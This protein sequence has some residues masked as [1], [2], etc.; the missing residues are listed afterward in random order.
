[1][2]LYT[3]SNAVITAISDVL[4]HGATQLSKW[5]VTAD[6]TID[7]IP[8]VAYHTPRQKGFQYR[9]QWN[10]MWFRISSTTVELLPEKERMVFYT[11]PFEH[12]TIFS[13][14]PPYQISETKEEVSHIGGPFIIMIQVPDIKD[15]KGLFVGTVLR[16]LTQPVSQ[17]TQYADGK[18]RCVFRDQEI[19][20]ESDCYRLA[21]PSEIMSYFYIHS[22]GAI[23]VQSG[24]HASGFLATIKNVNGTDVVY[25]TYKGVKAVAVSPDYTVHINYVF[26]PTREQ[27]LDYKVQEAKRD[28][29]EVGTIVTAPIIGEV[30]IQSFSVD[31]T[32]KLIATVGKLGN[33]ASAGMIP[34]ASLSIIREQW[35]ITN[36]VALANQVIASIPN[37]ESSFISAAVKESFLTSLK[38]WCDNKLKLL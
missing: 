14:N 12:A 6:L 30:V 35:D 29:F 19:T 5:K 16:A 10:S 7:D 34:I 18:I 4:S 9:F 38:T 28:G 25:N 8:I 22:S 26:L 1:M 17:L 21:E 11:K 33:S 13:P 32:N 27:V 24:S 15:I 23:W 3:T 2:K 37:M 36:G 31:I 20:L